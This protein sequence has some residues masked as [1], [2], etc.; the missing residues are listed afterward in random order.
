MNH[1]RKETNDFHLPPIRPKRNQSSLTTVRD[2]STHITASTFNTKPSTPTLSDRQSSAT[3]DDLISMNSSK[4]SLP[5]DNEINALTSKIYKLPLPSNHSK[6]NKSILKK[7]S[8][9]LER[10]PTIASKSN[11]KKETKPVPSVSNTP[12][13]KQRKTP[14]PSNKSQ[15]S[16]TK[17]QQQSLSTVMTTTPR[18]KYGPQSWD[19]PYVGTRFDPPTPPSSPSYFPWSEFNDQYENEI[20]YILNSIDEIYF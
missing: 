3:R 20:P 2:S 9:S 19:E 1:S 6:L 17:K 5:I 7:R 8:K 18:S 15:R 12:V 13:P 16:I 11:E 10:K 4:S 14:I